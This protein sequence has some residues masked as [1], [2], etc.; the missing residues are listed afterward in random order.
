MNKE[1][2]KVSLPVLFF[3]ILVTMII[4]FI[5]TFIFLKKDYNKKF[6]NFLLIEEINELLDKVFYKDSV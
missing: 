6:E 5:T 3:L 2:T 4:T 1:R